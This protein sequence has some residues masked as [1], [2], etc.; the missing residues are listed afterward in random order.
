MKQLSR[1]FLFLI[2]ILASTPAS[3]I[4][5]KEKSW[6]EISSPQFTVFSDAGEKK[7]RRIIHE[8]EKFHAVIRQFIPSIQASPSIPTIIL[9]AENERS[10]RSLLPQFWEKRGLAHPSGIF[11]GG[12]ERNYV[13]LRLDLDDDFRYHIVYHEY[14]HLL[15]RLNFPPLA[16]WLSEGLAECFGYAVISDKSAL[17]GRPSPEQLQI[18]RN[19]QPI[20]ITDLFAVDH[21]SPYYQEESKAS[22]FY[23][24]SWALTHL[25]LLGDKGTNAPKLWKYL[26][27]IQN[28]VSNDEA[29]AQAFGDLK[30]LERRLN[31]YILQLSFY[32]F[33]VK[34]PSVKDPK[35]YP[36]R[37]VSSLEINAVQGD[38]FV[39]TQRWTEAKEMLDRVLQEDP[40]N[41]AAHSSLGF[42]YQQRN[43]RDA[44]QKHFMI[45]AKSGSQSCLVH[46][47]L[48]VEES[49]LGEYEQAESSYRK[50]IELNPKFAPAYSRLAWT[51][52]M[53]ESKK[54]E[55]LQFAIKAINLEPGVL[56][57]KI[58][59]AT[60]L[61]RM[62][63]VDEAIQ[64]GEKIES[65][66]DSAADRASIKQFLSSARTYQRRLKEQER[67][68]EQSGIRESGR[69]GY[70]QN[71]DSNIAYQN[72]YGEN[73]GILNKREEEYDRRVKAEQEYLK[74]VEAAKTKGI[75]AMQGMV[76]DLQCPDAAIMELHISSNGNQYK[77]H[78]ANYF[79]IDYMFIG[80]AYQEELNPCTDLPKKR[81]AIK[82]I[83]TPGAAYAGEIMAM[84]IY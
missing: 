32:S 84:D 7:A 14:V 16:T 21:E 71:E 26:E 65:A 77:F 75:V 5:A 39:S 73:Q 83:A 37:T 59:L 15:M 23:A 9:A 44:A 48:G 4:P 25:L 29:T 33:K 53:N 52:A 46:Y 42:F 1:C 2:F 61:M 70:R 35:E 58:T 74:T 19:E 55:A 40:Q 68:R 49:S 51:L 18:L 8:F 17:V 22:I 30:A 66:A 11:V 38:F 63:R 56:H 50:A 20:P 27:L 69:N 79:E 6:I 34:T 41:A 45:A 3:P 82:Y 81:V 36:V 43:Q 80:D 64:L 24:Q 47:Y 12:P 28:N 78:V 76:T 62:Q 67:L 54:E 31:E 60:V 57:H 72:I 10:L 13:A